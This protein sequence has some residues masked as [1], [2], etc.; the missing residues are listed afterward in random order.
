MDANVN[1]ALNLALFLNVHNI[2]I[3]LEELFHT[4]VGLSFHGDIRMQYKME[5]PNKIGNLV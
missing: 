2:E 4:I 1:M 5:N 3:S